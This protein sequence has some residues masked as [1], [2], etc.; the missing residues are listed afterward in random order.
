MKGASKAGRGLAQSAYRAG[1]THAEG[2]G[3]AVSAVAA[4]ASHDAAPVLQLEGITKEFGAIRALHDINMA[5]NPA[6]WSG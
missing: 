5:I 1:E 6:T 4:I 3:S 2:E